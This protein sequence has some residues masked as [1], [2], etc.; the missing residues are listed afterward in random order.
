VVLLTLA[1]A[2]SG[3]II[4]NSV[5]DSTVGSVVFAIEGAFVL[6]MVTAGVLTYDV[7][8]SAE[9]NKNTNEGSQNIEEKSNND[10]R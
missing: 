2:L 5:S 9:E 1:G 7:I 6:I 8:E 10:H 4:R 3:E